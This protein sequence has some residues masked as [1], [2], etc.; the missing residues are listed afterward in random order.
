MRKQNTTLDAY[1]KD[2]T[3]R[4]WKNIGNEIA[5]RGYSIRGISARAR[6]NHS[7]VLSHI[8]DARS[9]SPPQDTKIEIYDQ[10]CRA[11]GKPLSYFM[12]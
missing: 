10:L 4:I 9:D 7:V 6:V 3:I 5:A 2:T 11:L 8:R 12:Q 1:V